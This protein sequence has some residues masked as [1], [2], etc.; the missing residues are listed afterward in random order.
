MKF[1][2][3]T[4]NNSFLAEALAALSPEIQEEIRRDFESS[5]TQGVNKRKSYDD[6]GT[7]SKKI[8]EYILKD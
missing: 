8:R 4:R 6:I 7:L 5:K 3:M 1:E 2:D